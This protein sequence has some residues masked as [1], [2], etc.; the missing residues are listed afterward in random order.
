MNQK[1]KGRRNFLIIYGSA[2][3]GVSFLGL[4][5]NLPDLIFGHILILPFIL[6]PSF[7]PVGLAYLFFGI[8][9]NNIQGKRSKVFLWLNIMSLI[10]Y[11]MYLAGFFLYTLHNEG[12]Q[13]IHFSEVTSI[14]I[15]ISPIIAPAAFI[16]PGIFIGIKLRKIEKA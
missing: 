8:R 14:L 13:D 4:L 15:S 2:M 9:I 7:L 10:W 16:I 6:I 1:L 12:Q 11:L 5:T 3:A